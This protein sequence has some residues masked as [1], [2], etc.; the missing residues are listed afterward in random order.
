MIEKT[1]D[2]LEIGDTLCFPGNP[3][4][5]VGRFRE[6]QEWTIRKFN[7]DGTIMVHGLGGLCIQKL[8]KYQVKSKPD[9]ENGTLRT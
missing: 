3:K 1:Y 8:E 7:E 2:E 9:Q 5:E 4:A 6:P